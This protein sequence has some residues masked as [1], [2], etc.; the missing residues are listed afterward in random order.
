[1]EV[2]PALTAHSQFPTESILATNISCEPSVKRVI[3]PKLLSPWKVPV[4]NNEPP[5][6]FDIELLR[7]TIEPP[8]LCTHIQLPLLSIFATN[9]SVFPALVISKGPK[10]ATPW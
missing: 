10:F 2:P 5:L 3:S 6:S 7:S 8:A 4:I 9:I 1:M